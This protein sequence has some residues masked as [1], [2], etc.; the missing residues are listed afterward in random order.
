[1]YACM[2]LI[3]NK[4]LFKPKFARIVPFFELVKDYTSPICP[5]FAVFEIITRA[6]DL[7]FNIFDSS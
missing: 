1:M 2:Y 3:M 4:V 7:S 6:R 5:V